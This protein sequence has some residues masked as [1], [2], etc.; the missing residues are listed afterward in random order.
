LRSKKSPIF[1]SGYT[2]SSTVACC[3]YLTAN[4]K[5]LIYTTHIEKANV[6]LYSFILRNKITE[7][8]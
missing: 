2:Y 3:G 5:D 8:Q 4:Q 6:S 1:F 7:E